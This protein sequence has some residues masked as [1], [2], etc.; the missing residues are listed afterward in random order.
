M[1]LTVA[2]MIKHI[3]EKVKQLA[4]AKSNMKKLDLEWSQ[5]RQLEKDR[6][7]EKT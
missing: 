5:T 2:G 4:G 7:L 1:V 6:T 3:Y